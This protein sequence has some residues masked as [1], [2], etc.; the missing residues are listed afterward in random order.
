[1]RTGCVGYHFGPERL[2]VARKT[3]ER[4]VAR[5]RQLYEQEPGEPIASA[6]LGAYVQRWVRWAGVG[7]LHVGLPTPA[8]R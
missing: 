5:A 2:E 4:F 1:M 7:G 6:R 8:P 3:V